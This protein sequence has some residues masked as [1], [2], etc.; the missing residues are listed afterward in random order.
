MMGILKD[1][2]YIFLEILYP[3]NAT[4]LLLDLVGKTMPEHLSYH[5]LM[6]STK[7]NIQAVSLMDYSEYTVRKLIHI[8]K[9]TGDTRV[10][11]LLSTILSSYILEYLSEILDMDTIDNLLILP[12]PLSDNRR[13]ERGFSQLELLLNK[14][15]SNNRSV[16]SC[17][18]YDILVKIV[19]TK[20]QTKLNRKER[21]TN[22]KGV[23]RLTKDNLVKYKHIILI[24]DVLTTGATVAEACRV[25]MK[26]G[27]KCVDVV[28]LARSI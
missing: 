22:V 13:K 28:T 18:R 20:P 1:I 10:I 17:I 26:G 27:A 3:D 9:Y 11:E 19:D 16:L 2:Y 6:I 23:F 21:L 12:I 7:Y 25:L 15:F 5:Q 8:F 24:D 14:S 4:K